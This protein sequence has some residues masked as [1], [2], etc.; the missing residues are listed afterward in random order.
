MFELAYKR[1]L[2]QIAKQ[3]FFLMY[4]LG[5]LLSTITY[6]STVCF[7]SHLSKFKMTHTL[8][9]H[10]LDNVW[11]TLMLLASAQREIEFAS[12]PQTPVMQLHD[13]TDLK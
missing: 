4:A 9:M 6:L 3:A 7:D 2:L 8:V 13:C 10:N 11:G 1:G 5:N 12:V